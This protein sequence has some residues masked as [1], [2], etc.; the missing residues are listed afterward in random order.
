MLPFDVFIV[1]SVWM[2]SENIL[3]SDVRAVV[4]DRCSVDLLFHMEEGSPSCKFYKFRSGSH[5]A[6]N[7][8]QSI[9]MIYSIIILIKM[10]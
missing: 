8:L 6:K 9:N 7:C 4:F 10:P 3:L 5:A 2:D 1:M